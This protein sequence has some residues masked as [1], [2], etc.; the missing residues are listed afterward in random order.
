MKRKYLCS[1]ILIFFLSLSLTPARSINLWDYLTLRI[2]NLTW[3]TEETSWH[4]IG[5]SIENESKHVFAYYSVSN[6]QNK[7]HNDEIEL[8]GDYCI[9]L[10]VSNRLE[11]KIKVTIKPDKY[12]KLKYL[13]GYSEDKPSLQNNEL[14]IIFLPVD[15]KDK[16]NELFPDKRNVNK[17]RICANT[18]TIIIPPNNALIL[19]CRLTEC[20]EKKALDIILNLEISWEEY[21][22]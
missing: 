14:K 18:I 15:F 1:S 6:M 20:N 5:K 8:C 12:E 19:P 9:L 17:T 10:Y 22:P 3:Y 11:K 4:P 7:F 21:L 2:Q 13:Y 16:E